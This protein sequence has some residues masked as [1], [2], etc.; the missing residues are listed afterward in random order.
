MRNDPSPT[1][2]DTDSGD[3]NLVLADKRNISRVKARTSAFQLIFQQNV[4]AKDMKDLLEER[5][6]SEV[7]LDA[8]GVRLIRMTLENLSEID[9]AIQPHLKRWT[10]SRL[11][12]V[13]LAILRISCAQL[14]YINK[15]ELPASVVIN[16]AVE[17]AKKF[18]A[19][20]EYS[21]VN[22]TL[23]SI[24]SALTEEKP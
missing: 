15:E 21:F 7:P 11:P 19:E 3:R 23:R 16:E 9:S 5:D 20:D 8:F 18:G 14:F 4:N 1:Q 24:C 2:T 17:L 22:G 6:A 10:L 12:K 13:S